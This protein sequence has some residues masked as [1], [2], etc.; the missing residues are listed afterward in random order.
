MIRGRRRDCVPLDRGSDGKL[1]MGLEEGDAADYTP[2]QLESLVA[3]GKF[4]ADE[5]WY[6]PIDVETK[7]PIKLADASVEIQ[8]L[9]A[10]GG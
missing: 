5:L 4:R 9:S 3:S 6:R 10:D 8:R 1:A 2:E 7:K